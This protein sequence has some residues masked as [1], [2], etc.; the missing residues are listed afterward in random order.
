MDIAAR[1]AGAF[2][3]AQAASLD[4]SRRQLN[5]AA[6][7]GILDRMHPAVFRFTSTTTG[8]ATR[9][10]GA[11]LQAGP[12]AVVS[13]E[14]CLF[15]QRVPAV[16]F[17]PV[18]TLPADGRGSH[19]GFRAHRL[20]DLR[21]EQVVEVD[22]LRTT[23]LERA[24]V[25]VTSVFSRVRIEWLVDRLTITDRRTSIGGIGR[26]L[27]QV[28]RRGR[29]HIGVLQDVLD[30]RRPGRPAPRSR[31]E[32]TVDA[33]LATTGLPRPRHEFPLPS[34]APGEGLVDRAWP[35]AKLILEVDGR[36]WHARE[37]AMAQD[38]RRDRIAAAQGWLTLRVLD[39]E[40]SDLPETVVD[41][42]VA[43]YEAR[44]LLLGPELAQS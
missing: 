27:R 7:N 8:P 16:P 35:E 33:L 15:L 4:L 3:V 18:V 13:H 6:A 36:V 43:A 34:A 37:R 17:Q 29:E 14:S 10:W 30:Q 5:A 32:T 2:S 24:L 1:Q 28:N 41:D 19:R 40:V 23:T 39:E 22:G 26:V 21:P 25:D 9:I 44:I 42:V 11:V 38:R 12:L 20:G 31:L